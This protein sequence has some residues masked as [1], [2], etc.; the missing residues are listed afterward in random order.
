MSDN[1]FFIFV[2][3]S[4]IYTLYYLIHAFYRSS[5]YKILIIRDL[6]V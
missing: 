6:N 5:Y 1:Q 3:D 2:L 4:L